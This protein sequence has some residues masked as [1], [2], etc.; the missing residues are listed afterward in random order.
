MI[1]S[2]QRNLISVGTLFGTIALL[3][4]ICLPAPLQ[5][6]DRADDTFAV[7]GIVNGLTGKL[8]IV[9]DRQEMLGLS[10]DGKFSFA[11]P[12]KKGE[13]YAVRIASQPEEMKCEIAEGAGIISGTDITNI[14][15]TCREVRRWFAPGNPREHISLAGRDA[16]FPSTAIN[17]RGDVIV[18]WLQNDGKHWRVYKSEKRNGSWQHPSSLDD[19]LS[20]SGNVMMTRPQVAINDTGEALIAWVQSDSSEN[21]VYL[22]QSSNNQW[23]NPAS[24]EEKISPAGGAVLGPQLALN[25]QGEAIIVWFQDARDGL[26]SIFRSTRRNGQWDHPDS[27]GNYISLDAG[28]DASNPVVALNNKGEAVISWEHTFGSISQIYMSEF[29]AGNWRNPQQVEDH[30][31]TGDGHRGAYSPVA[32][33]ADNGDAVIVWRQTVQARSLLYRSEK[34][35]GSWSHPA[36]ADGISAT[37]GMAAAADLAMDETGN[38]ILVWTEK[39]RQQSRIFQSEYRE[40]TWSKPL[41][42]QDNLSKE[43]LEPYAFGPQAVMT[44]TGRGLVAWLQADKR[45][46]FHIFKSVF[47]NGKWLTPASEEDFLG[48]AGHPVASFASDM[49]ASGDAIIAWQQ[50][51]GNN[52]LIY[53]SEYRINE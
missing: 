31:S 49:A 44:D 42:L 4:S 25:D 51:D 21:H 33:I 24:L 10:A 37:G 39:K 5:A 18:A 29:R 27:L 6:G 34:R 8:E 52:S 30:I 50:S 22:S 13:S 15:V 23:R 11:T 45:G 46:Q 9:N 19:A 26:Y 41:S 35:N 47:R 28:F 53:S 17:S 40:G 2:I 43:R 3:A 7:S 16:R 48:F 1:N 38:T 32:A 20:P 12:Y 14:A 36:L